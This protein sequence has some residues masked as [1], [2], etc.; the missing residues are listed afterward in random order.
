[1]TTKYTYLCDTA[2]LFRRNMLF[3]FLCKSPQSIAISQYVLNRI[4]ATELTRAKTFQLFFIFS[5]NTVL[6]TTATI[7]K[8]YLD[9]LTKWTQSFSS[10]SRRTHY[11]NEKGA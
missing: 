3:D 5:S 4:A 2:S 8:K 6:T 7:V 9:P 11:N 10:N 1:M